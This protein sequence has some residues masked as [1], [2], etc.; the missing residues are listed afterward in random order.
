MTTYTLGTTRRTLLVTE[1]GPVEHASTGLL[2]TPHGRTL[3]ALCG[4]GVYERRFA[5]FNTDSP[6]ACRG[7]LKAIEER[8]AA[9]HA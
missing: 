2:R 6:R 9:R 7:C 5:T 3:R 1:Y 4:A 8:E